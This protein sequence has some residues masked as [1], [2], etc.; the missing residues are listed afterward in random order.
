[1]KPFDVSKVKRYTINL[2][3][4]QLDII[5]KCLQY[6]AYNEFTINGKIQDEEKNSEMSLIRDTYHQILSE[7]NDQNINERRRTKKIFK[8]IS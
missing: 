8:K 7:R 6:Y 4:S 5:F 2:L 3:D 1:M